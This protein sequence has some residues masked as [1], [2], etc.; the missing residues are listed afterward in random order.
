MIVPGRDYCW[1]NQNVL[2]DEQASRINQAI[3][4]IA[5]KENWHSLVGW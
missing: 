4:M 1:L 2:K 3:I 5:P